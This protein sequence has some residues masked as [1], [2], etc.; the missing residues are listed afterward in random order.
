M[1]HHLRMHPLVP[2]ESRS[3]AALWMHLSCP[4]AFVDAL[5]CEGPHLEHLTHSRVPPTIEPQ[6][7]QMNGVLPKHLSRP[8]PL[9]QN[10]GIPAKKGNPAHVRELAFPR[11]PLVDSHRYC[12]FRSRMRICTAN[13]VYGC[14][15]VPRIPFMDAYLYLSCG[16]HEMALEREAASREAKTVP[17]MAAKQ[18]MSLPM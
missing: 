13:F 2:L 3:S 16:V 12:E 7:Y 17:M 6:L 18:A 14:V 9:E 11:I 10:H 15:F 5:F 8:L 4:W 1:A